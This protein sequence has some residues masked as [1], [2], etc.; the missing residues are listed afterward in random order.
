MKTVNPQSVIRMRT[1]IPVTTNKLWR[2]MLVYGS[3]N[4]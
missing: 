3:N 1:D 2:D 4:N